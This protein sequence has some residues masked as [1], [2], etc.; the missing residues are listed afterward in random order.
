MRARGHK[1][2]G[3]VEALGK[4]DAVVVGQRLVELDQVVSLFLLNL[5]CEIGHQGFD[6]GNEVGVGGIQVLEFLEFLFHLWLSVLI[7]GD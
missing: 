3:P 7:T 4:T 6:G 2:L 5:L 1:H